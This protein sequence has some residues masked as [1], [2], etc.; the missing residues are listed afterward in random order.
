[1][2][3]IEIGKY[4]IK[5]DDFLNYSFSCS[6][7]NA[8]ECYKNKKCCCSIFHIETTDDN[9]DDIYS[10]IDKIA[11]YC[12]NLI[13][14][15]EYQDVFL[16]EEDGVF[17][18]DK[19]DNDD[20]IFSYLDKGNSLRCS[21]HSVALDINENPVIYKPKACISWPIMIHECDKGNYILAL[22]TETK[23]SCIKK[24]DKIDNE[25]DP[26]LFNILESLLGSKLFKDFLAKLCL[27][28]T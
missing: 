14:D 12:P 10:I 4:S 23:T 6:D 26:N 9:V 8:K 25:I 2:K 28:F 22:D 16:D 15:G 24:K 17:S 3:F 18:I 5:I 13:E 21:I 1:M 27:F 7:Q 20:C 11:K 19:T